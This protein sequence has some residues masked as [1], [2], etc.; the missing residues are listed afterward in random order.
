ML[1]KGSACSSVVE[2]SPGMNDPW[3]QSW[4]LESPN[5]I[6]LLK[7]QKYKMLIE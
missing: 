4:A 5:E 3:F 7:E 6:T 2:F 1:A